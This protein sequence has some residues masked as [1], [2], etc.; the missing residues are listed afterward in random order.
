M[1]PVHG[2]PKRSKTRAASRTFAIATWYKVEEAI[3]AD[4]TYK[5]KRLPI[6]DSSSWN[7][8]AGG[9][10]TARRAFIEFPKVAFN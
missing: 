8:D 5:I 6:P 1:H 3:A 4:G 7:A 2:P 10:A 9:N